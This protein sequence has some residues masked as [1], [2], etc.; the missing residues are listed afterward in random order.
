MV[1]VHINN[2]KHI[3]IANIYIPPRDN[4]STHYKTADMDIQHITNISHSVLTGE[5]NTHCTLRHSYTGDHSGQLLAHVI[6][7]S[8]NITL[9]TNTPT[10]QPNT[11]LQQTS[12]PDITTVSNTLYNRTSW[13]T[14]HA[15]SSDHLHIIT[16]I[17]IRH[18][19]RVQQNGSKRHSLQ[20]VELSQQSGKPC[21]NCADP[22]R[23]SNGDPIT[24][25][26]GNPAMRTRW[27]AGNA[28][29]FSTVIFKRPCN[30]KKLRARLIWHLKYIVGILLHHSEVFKTHSY[31]WGSFP[32]LLIPH[33]QH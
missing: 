1:M 6:S 2:T 15:V 4:T 31:V 29:F 3:R 19:Y 32:N 26:G 21:E 12:S 25:F 5:V 30:E 33:F 28:P 20:A 10:R 27:M 24:V 7:N 11:T 22:S 13:T 18:D 23:P 9:N 8:D 17:N 14:Q 16:T